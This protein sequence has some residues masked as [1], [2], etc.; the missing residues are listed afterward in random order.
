MLSLAPCVQQQCTGRNDAGLQL[1]SATALRILSSS[2]A[3]LEKPPS[4]RSVSL[5]ATKTS[6]TADVQL[7]SAGSVYCA[8]YRSAAVLSAPTSVSAVLLQKLTA[9]TDARNVSSVVVSALDAASTYKL[10]FLTVSPV[11]VMSSLTEVLASVHEVTTD[12]CKS[13]TGW[14]RARAQ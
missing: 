14:R 7:S 13:V 6:M 10:Y 8:V 4:L 12:C 3:D 5:Q 9:N 2:F 11:G 1:T